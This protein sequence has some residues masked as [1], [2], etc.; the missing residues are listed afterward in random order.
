MSNILKALNNNLIIGRADYHKENLIVPYIIDC[1]NNNRNIVVLDAS[2]TL[3]KKS[4]KYLSDSDYSILS[5][6]VSNPSESSLWNPLL[7]P[8]R[9]Y[10]NGDKDECVS[11][12]YNI[13]ATIM[14]DDIKVRDKDPYWE[15]AATDYFVGLALI[16]FLEAENENQINIENIYRIAKDGSKKISSSTYIKEYVSR[17]PSNSYR[18][19]NILQT[20]IAAPS[21]TRASI[22]SVF[23]ENLNKI[24][25]YMSFFNASSKESI[26]IDMLINNKTAIFISYSDD[27]T[28]DLQYVKV[29][30][31]QLSHMMLKKISNRNT[32]LFNY[33]FSDFLSLGYIKDFTRTL[34]SN[35]KYG[36][37]YLIDIDSFSNAGQLYGNDFSEYLISVCQGII[38]MP[39]NEIET[40]NKVNKLYELINCDKMKCVSPYYLRPNTALIIMQPN[41]PEVILIDSLDHEDEYDLP[42]INRE[43]YQIVEFDINGIVEERKQQQ[44]LRMM[45]AFTKNESAEQMQ[46]ILHPEL[47]RDT[48]VQSTQA[49]PNDKNHLMS[50]SDKLMEKIEQKIE[51]TK[52]IENLNRYINNTNL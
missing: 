38:V 26:D 14:A 16:L 36:N 37:R 3:L 29:F 42:K 47:G 10:Q 41:D 44:L 46:A 24:I 17:M 19:D 25:K 34:A 18:I 51:Q 4:G 39:S 20:V 5:I 49:I 6:N 22:E 31:S 13:A 43:P 30:L 52:L 32:L 7:I 1:I 50:E 28:T 15:N 35:T 23:Y 27:R 11:E 40:L 45:N 21:D 8:Y 48:L 9:A 2:K 12:L 33:I